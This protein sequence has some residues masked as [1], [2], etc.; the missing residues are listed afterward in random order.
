MMPTKPSRLAFLSLLILCLF[1]Q[2]SRSTLHAQ[3]WPQW[4][5]PDGQGHASATNLPTT[6]GDTSNVVWRTS[7]PG[8]GWSSPVMNERQIWMTAASESEPT[9][10]DLERLSQLKNARMLQISGAVAMH[11]LCV[12]RES[13][14]VLHD[15]ELAVE[16]NPQPIHELNSYAS[17]TPILDGDR[18]YCH[19]GAHGTVCVDTTSGDVLW[20]NM[21]IEVQHE[22][23]PG[24]TPVLWNNR[25]ILTCDGTDVQ[26]VAALDTETGEE[27][28]R[29][30][31][32]GEMDSN[33]QFQKAYGTPIV[34]EVE[35]TPQLISPGADWVY[36]YNPENGEELWRVP[37]G[38][39][40]F[41]IVPRPVYG[42]GMVYFSTSFMKPEILAIEVKRD[43]AEI[44]W[45][46]ARQAPRMPSPLLVADELY[47]VSDN[48]IASCLDAETGEIIWAERLGGN[49]S[50]S[51]LY[52]DGKIFVGNRTGHLYVFQ[53]GREFKL[54]A[55]NELDGA[56]MATPAAVGDA[57]YV[58]TEH[59]LYRIAKDSNE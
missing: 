46:Q 15:I 42:N 59:S 33:P 16:E 5:G 52:A 24:S 14:E 13:G 48:G 43:E 21:D 9:D 37:Y 44:K 12:D 22:N 55:D 30:T 23:G 49:F 32:S 39:L 1:V 47:M 51:P 10:E 8:K 40:G 29:T 11:V 17:P 28:W 38:G 7:L 27:V 56:V 57:L 36:A 45:R 4:R 3:T 31:R 26:Y 25:L 54:L 35:G 53:P 20:K 50:S 34:I 41:S 58:R 19:F 18:L 2:F 6:F